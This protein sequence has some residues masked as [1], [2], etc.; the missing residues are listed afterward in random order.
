MV[1]AEQQIGVR[2]I[3][4]QRRTRADEPMYG[5][6]VCNTGFSEKRIWRRWRHS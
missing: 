3:Q 1:G 5:R 4:V 6:A 2:G